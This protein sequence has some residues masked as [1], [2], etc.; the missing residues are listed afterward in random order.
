MLLQKKEGKL[1]LVYAISRELSDAER[2]YHSTKLEQLA[3]IWSMERLRHYLFGRKFTVISYCSAVSALTSESGSPQINRW[4]N[5]ISEFDFEV[6]HRAR[7]AMGH[8]DALS[9]A[10]IEEADTGDEK[11][12]LPMDSRIKNVSSVVISARDITTVQSADEDIKEKVKILQK[13]TRNRTAAEKRSVD[14]YKE[15]QGVLF[16]LVNDKKLFVVPKKMRKY[17]LVISHDKA[18]HFGTRATLKILQRMYW[19]P[20]MRD[21]VKSIWSVSSARI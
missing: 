9:R 7:A 15:K 16:R 20:R 12:E 10:P 6:K 14:G 8:A 18:G 3:V 4:L 1:R 17:M 2:N 11:D 21:Y 19:F 5:K 13:A